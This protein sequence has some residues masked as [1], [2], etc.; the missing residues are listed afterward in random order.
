MSPKSVLLLGTTHSVQMGS[1]QATA[2]DIEAFRAGVLK[3]C[4]AHGIQAI[5]E[6]MSLD[7]LKHWSCSETIAK[8]ISSDRGLPHRYCDP[9]HEE[10]K[11]LGA[12]HEEL[13]PGVREFWDMPPLTPEQAE[14]IER[15]AFDRREEE[16]IRRILDLNVWPLLYIC[17]SN[18]V[19]S[20]TEKLAREGMAV[21]DVS[22]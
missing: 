4:E 13:H 15:T 5:G 14:A 17:G 8:G 11:I 7:A 1:R 9:E 18:H 16:W 21:Q 19:T 3:L 6:E 10:R 12:I 2:E 20:F 22:L